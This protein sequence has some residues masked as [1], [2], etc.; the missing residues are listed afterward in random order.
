MKKTISLFAIMLIMV[1]SLYAA[2]VSFTFDRVFS[3]DE[4][5]MV[6][7]PFG[8]VMSAVASEG[9]IM[10]LADG[11][12][13]T[14][15]DSKGNSFPV[16][17]V[18]T[19]EETIPATFTWKIDTV[20]EMRLRSYLNG[21]SKSSLSPSD[22]V[23][24]YRRVPVNTLSVFTLE[25]KVGKGKWYECG[26]LGILPVTPIKESIQEAP[27]VRTAAPQ[28]KGEDRIKTLEPVLS[29]RNQGHYYD[30]KLIV[31]GYFLGAMNITDGETVNDSAWKAT[32]SLP[33]TRNLTV[34]ADGE[35]QRFSKTNVVLATGKV[36]LTS[37]VIESG[38]VFIQA[39]GGAKFVIGDD[40]TQPAFT[41]GLGM[42]LYFTKN[43]GLS[44]IADYTGSIADG[45]V[46]SRISAGAGIS[47]AFGRD[48]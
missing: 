42:E 11:A 5:V 7:D 15:T 17:V 44:L 8:T 9:L 4:K 40:F 22:T 37:P 12:T 23:K 10:N 30:R 38:I 45:Q 33:L 21:G 3:G 19:E 20:K 48:I 35:Y 2:R 18:F 36:R 34:S 16:T 31:S 39:G 6:T 28:A 32:L 43:I 29:V 41:L 14:V 13:I 26:K 25:A 47:L 27:E 46:M 1:S 24:T